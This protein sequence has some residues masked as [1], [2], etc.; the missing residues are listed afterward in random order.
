M[1]NLQKISITV[2]S[3]AET[4][5]MLQYPNI[6]IFPFQNISIS[7][8]LMTLENA[9]R[10]FA[11]PSVIP[12]EIPENW[13]IS[14]EVERQWCLHLVSDGFRLDVWLLHFKSAWTLGWWQ[15][16]QIGTGYF[17]TNPSLP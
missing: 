5:G 15:I 13:E 4:G 2:V 8:L 6:G 12:R 14:I 1:L 7:Y 9:V 10:V 16:I 11:W 3:P 17:T